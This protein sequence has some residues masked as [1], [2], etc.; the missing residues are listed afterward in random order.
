MRQAIEQSYLNHEGVKNGFARV[1]VNYFRMGNDGVSVQ[2]LVEELPY[3]LVRLGDFG[4]LVEVITCPEF[5][6]S[7]NSEENQFDFYK[8]WR[9]CEEQGLHPADKI[10]ENLKKVT[11][12]TNYNDKWEWPLLIIFLGQLWFYFFG[13]GWK[14]PSRDCILWSLGRC[15]P[16]SY[17]GVSRR[18]LRKCLRCSCGSQC[19]I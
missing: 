5:F 4:Q 15:F 8:Y 16:H 2:R 13:R 10:L 12:K 18:T 9:M 1:L 6:D 17:Q 3:Q 7:L 14:I 19:T 11:M